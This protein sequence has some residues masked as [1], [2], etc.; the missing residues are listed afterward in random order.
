MDNPR[1]SVNAIKEKEKEMFEKAAHHSKS[2]IVIATISLALFADSLQAMIKDV[3]ILPQPKPAIIGI[4][5]DG[6]ALPAEEA[7]ESTS[8]FA[9]ALYDEKSRQL[10]ECVQEVNQKVLGGVEA[11]FMRDLMVHYTDDGRVMFSW[12]DKWDGNGNMIGG[13]NVPSITKTDKYLTLS[14]ILIVYESLVS[15]LETVQQDFN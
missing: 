8:E 7:T 12:K 5:E 4:G 3:K 13:G 10:L 15:K 14:E 11:V 6:P 2:F 9:R 1:V